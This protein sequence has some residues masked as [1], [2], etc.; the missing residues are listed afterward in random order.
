MFKV[1]NEIK[2]LQSKIDLLMHQIERNRG[3]QNILSK[4]ES[5]LRQLIMDKKEMFYN[6]VYPRYY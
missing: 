1:K 3:E 5:K 2:Q 4:E 6:L